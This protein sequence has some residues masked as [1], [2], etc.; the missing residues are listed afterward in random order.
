MLGYLILFLIFVLLFGMSFY[1]AFREWL[2]PEDN[3]PIPVDVEYVRVENYFG[4]SFRAKMQEWLETAKPVELSE[5]LK[6]PVEAVL[7]KPNGERILLLN[8]GQFGGDVEHEELLCCDGDLSIADLSVFRREV[9]AR[10]KVETGAGV[11][12]QALAAD[13]D[14]MLGVDN[15]VARWVDAIGKIWLRRGTLVHAR[16]SSQESIQLDIGVTSQSMYAPLI[17]T[18]GYKPLA[19][20]SAPE[21]EALQALADVREGMSIAG[22]PT[23]VARLAADTLLVRG[24]LELKPGSRVDSNLIVQGTLRSGPD[25]AFL[26]DVKAGTVELGVRNEI[27]RN[28][29]SGSTLKL[30]D[31]CRVSKAVVAETDILLSPGTRVGQPGKLAVVTAGRNIKLEQDVAIW[32]KVAAGK[33]ITTI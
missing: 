23:G 25:C 13:R 1:F 5:P 4:T 18:A 17:F 9:Y 20:Y 6:P 11:Q 19:G 24:D 22:L 30:G 21:E 8:P 12:L 3:T 32:G 26:G 10:G 31:S 14:V 15:D 27:S 7:E 16:V 33:S 29:V 28:L 2:R